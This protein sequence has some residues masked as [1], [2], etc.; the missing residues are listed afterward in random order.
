MT[1]TINEQQL[2]EACRETLRQWPEARAA[3]LF[4]SRARG[5]SRKD[6]DWDVAIVLSGGNP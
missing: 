4:G 6:S 5:T 3:L 1:A 2:R